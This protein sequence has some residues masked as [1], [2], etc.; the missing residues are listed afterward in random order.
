M[1]SLRA[2][3]ALSVVASSFLCI[4]LASCVGDDP[5]TST[6][7]GTTPDGA[8]PVDGG[9]G[10]A[11]SP[12]ASCSS[13]KTECTKGA[14]SVC[15]DTATDDQNCGKCG[16]VCGAGAT[17]KA[18]ACVCTDATQTR[19]G[20]VCVD[21]KTNP[22]HCG[23]CGNACPNNRCTV[24]ECDRIVFVTSTSNNGS[25]NGV[26]GADA[27]CQA[28]AV[29]GGLKGT[30]Q[31]WI[32]AG[33]GPAARFTTK[34]ATPYVLPNGTTK[35]AE[36]F[37]TLGDSGGLLH[38]IDMTELK[39]TVTSSASVMTN[40]R[41]NG[42]NDSASFDCGGWTSNDV[43][44]KFYPGTATSS[45]AATWSTNGSALLTCDVLDYRLYCFQQ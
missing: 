30:Y 35:V 2:S 16:V 7:G 20:D 42:D 25:L 29:A 43:A 13:P 1:T 33:V 19:C 11:D 24:G 39:T 44:N 23:K 37:A 3:L 34:S 6:T 5:A 45:A 26:A 38:A 4:V 21:T 32:S 14:T 15:T 8:A 28:R 12:S 17:C 36:S 22:S 41:P 18:S 31:A 9:G 40:A 10:G 27:I